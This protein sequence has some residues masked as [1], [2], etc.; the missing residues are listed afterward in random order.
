VEVSAAL[1]PKQIPD[2]NRVDHDE[3]RANDDQKREKCSH[4]EVIGVALNVLD[5][6]DLQAKMGES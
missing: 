4:D 6:F 3:R 5:K 2:V 1:V